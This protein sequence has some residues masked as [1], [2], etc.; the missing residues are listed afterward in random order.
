MWKTEVFDSDNSCNRLRVSRLP[1][2]NQSKF[3]FILRMKFIRFKVSIF[4]VHVSGVSMRWTSFNCSGWMKRDTRLDDPW[5]LAWRDQR[6]QQRGGPGRGRFP[7]APIGAPLSPDLPLSLL[8]FLSSSTHLP[9]HPHLPHTHILGQ[10]RKLSGR[11]RR[12]PEI[13]VT[14]SRL[15][16]CQTVFRSA[17]L[18]QRWPQLRDRHV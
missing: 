12:Q 4:S 3:S 13:T 17:S 2:L 1:K 15:P 10:N 16:P 9:L 5:R 7:I 11:E 18:P 6:R 8:T 14:V